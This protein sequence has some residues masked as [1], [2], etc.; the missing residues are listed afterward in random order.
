MATPTISADV[1]NITPKLAAKYLLRNRNNRHL[2]EKTIAPLVQDMVNGNWRL[3]GE[4]IKFDT[5]NNLIDGQHRLV[6]IERAGI[7]LPVLVIRGVEPEAQLVIDTGRKRTGGNALQIA[8][9]G[10]EMTLRSAIATIG[11]TDDA[12]KLQYSNSPLLPATHSEIID[13]VRNHNL[14]DA[15]HYGGKV[16]R[17]MR[18]SKSSICY[19]YF[20]IAQVDQGSAQRFFSDIADLS[21]SGPGDPKNALVNKINKSREHFRGTGY[22]AKYVY[23]FLRAWEAEFLGQELRLIR[24]SIGNRALEMP[25]LSRYIPT[26]SADTD[27]NGE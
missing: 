14:D 9:E 11:L 17:M 22:R 27:D 1:E 24:D 8:L 15:I 4:A 13:W 26:D 10:T 18:G 16:H 5:D 21:T 6:A 20:K 2:S 7:S 3:T 19:A 25:D 12:G 23:H